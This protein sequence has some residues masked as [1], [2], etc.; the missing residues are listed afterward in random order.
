ME[1]DLCKIKPM[2]LT[3]ECHTIIQSITDQLYPVI[4]DHLKTIQPLKIKYLE[5]DSFA[6]IFDL[7][8]ELNDEFVS[9]SKYETRLMFPLI[10]NLLKE[11][12]KSMEN[13]NHATE[14]QN[15]ITKKED[16]INNLVLSLE[17]EAE[18]LEP[19]KKEP[20]LSIINI[21][22]HNYTNTKHDLHK[23]ILQLQRKKGII[24]SQQSEK[25]A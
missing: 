2:S 22:A 18:L 7:L 6:N 1:G 8:D 20:L 4:M 3:Q 12:C 10:L 15:L 17:V 13:C 24:V 25:E 16:R 11:D 23:C 5:D 19:E 21:F 9:L 14:L